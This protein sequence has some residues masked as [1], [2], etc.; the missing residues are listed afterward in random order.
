ML[1]FEPRPLGDTNPQIQVFGITRRTV[2]VTL[3]C[4]LCLVVQ[5]LSAAIRRVRVVKRRLY[6]AV[7]LNIGNHV[8]QLTGIIS[9]V[10]ASRLRAKIPSQRAA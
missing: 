9:W 2:N 4:R 1:G 3:F 10:M 5:E 7:F 8:C 6:V